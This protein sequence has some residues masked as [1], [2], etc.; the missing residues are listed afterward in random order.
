MTLHIRKNDLV[1]VLSGKD[2]GKTGKVLSVIPQK[3]KVVVQGVNIFKRHSKPSPKNQQGGIIA[4]EAPLHISRV[5]LYCSRCQ[6][7]VRFGV[8]LLEDG[9]K[10]R[11]CRKCGEAF[12]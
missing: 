2:K 7:G 6:K 8:R 12:A 4:R 1:Q 5:N 3:E 10:I 9:T 11:F